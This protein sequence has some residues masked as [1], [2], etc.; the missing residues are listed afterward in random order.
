MKIVFLSLH[1]GY[2]G[3][4]KTIASQ[5]NILCEKYTVE[6][7]CTYKL[8]ENLP[9]FIDPRVKITYLLDDKFKPNK[10]E[11]KEAIKEKKIIKIF[12]EGIISAKILWLRKSAMKKAVKNSDGDIIISTRLLYNKLLTDN[13]KGN[14][15]CIAQEHNNPNNNQR[16]FDKMFKSIKHMDYIMPVSENLSEYYKKRI[17]LSKTKCVYI[18]HFLDEIPEVS[19]NLKETNIIS[20]GRLSKEKGFID[21]IKVFK[22]IKE[23]YPKWKLNIV[24]DGDERKVIENKIKELNLQDYVTLHGFQNKQYINNL[25]E[26]SSIYCMTSFEESFGLVLLEAFSFGIPCVAFDSAQGACE[27]IKDNSNGFLI[28]GRNLQLME[29]KVALIID[30]ENKRL[31]MGK[32][33]RKISFKYSKENVKKQWYEFIDTIWREKC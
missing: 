13:C 3:A 1:L 22:L 16:Y 28:P 14:V 26:N 25:L 8:Y 6:I 29:E 27:I 20:I 10:D 17:N 30:N 5:A 31:E 12:K 21:L 32:T 33:A 18:P 2:G 9:F 23:D 7:L 11:I 24:G 15:I 4:E 19:S